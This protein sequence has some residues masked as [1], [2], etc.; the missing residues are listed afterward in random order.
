M[1]LRCVPPPPVFAAYLPAPPVSAAYLTPPA[2]EVRSQV[3]KKEVP[4]EAKG[5]RKSSVD[6]GKSSKKSKST[7]A[8]TEASSSGAPPC[9][10]LG[11]KQHVS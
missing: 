4:K 6:E 8:P 5:K 1:R 9:M 7:N 10:H 2:L 3:K 11:T